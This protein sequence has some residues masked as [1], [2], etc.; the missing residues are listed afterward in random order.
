VA[1]RGQVDDGEAEVAQGARAIEHHALVVRAAM[2]KG[3]AHA[4][5]LGP[6]RRL[7]GISVQEAGDAAHCGLSD[8]VGE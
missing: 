4:E 6:V 7:P 1:A 5:E 2:A 3:I 8:V